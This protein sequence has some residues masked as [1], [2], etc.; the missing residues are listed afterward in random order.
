MKQFIAMI[1]LAF[2]ATGAFAQDK[3]KPSPAAVAEGVI[4]GV[5]VK[6]T[7]S[8]PSARG[9][10]IV[11]GLDP[12]GKVWRTGANETTTIEFS[13][14]VKVEGKEVA[15]GKYGLFTIPGETE[16]VVILN[17]GIKWG[18]Y[19]Y[20]Q[21]EDV[22]RVN[23]KPAKPSAF[24]ETLNF[25]VEKNQVVLKFENNQVAFSVKK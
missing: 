14:P 15:A 21:E 8:A 7:Y 24:V 1:M 12:Y 20:K 9:R 17:T 23:V 4:D 25:T 10:K 6:I 2:V 13:A 3:A 18:A 5:N 11:G 16:W 22:I 19:T